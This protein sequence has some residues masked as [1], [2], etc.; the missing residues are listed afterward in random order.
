M[1]A[2]RVSRLR[3][4]AF[5]MVG[6]LLAAHAGA[7]DK[8]GEL[9][10]LRARIE[11]I[12]KTIEADAQRRDALANELKEAALAVQS[13]RE[14]VS[15]IRSQ[16]IASEQRLS[17]LKHDHAET[18]KQIAMERETLASQLRAAYINGREEQL[19]LLL[20]QQN[21]ADIG[22]MTTY[23]GYFARARADG[24]AAITDRL[25]HLDLLTERTTAETQ[26]LREIED[27]Q[28]RESKQLGL[29]R[30]NR[31]QTLAA[32]QSK[33][34]TRSDQASSLERQ[35]KALEKLIEEMQQAAR[36]FPVLPAQ[37]F[38][39]TQGKLP[40]PINGKVVANFGELRAGGPLKWEGMVIGAAP[41][42]QVR[43]LFH[44]RVVYADYLYGMG[45]MVMVDHGDGY[46]S[47]YGQQEQLYCKVGDTVSPGD[48]LGVLADQTGAASVSRGELHLE[49]RKGKQALDP[50]KWLRNP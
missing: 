28:T 26:R 18:E 20:N 42:T 8:E 43:A 12:R 36:D 39:R 6:L 49:I 44:G 14:K 11:T 29:A 23:Y 17:D 16:R 47:I 32:M 10:Q 41:G 1:F 35:A 30:A 40:W 15:Q 38:A 22:R 50:R 4:Q 46:S 13:A 19:V 25:A 24:I 21:P 31:A 33:I 2:I 27:A 5:L 37:G 48:V 9:K 45:L 34:R 7:A 3:W